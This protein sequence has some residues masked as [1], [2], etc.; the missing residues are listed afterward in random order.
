MSSPN[1]GAPDR[2]RVLLVEDDA[3][4]RRSLQLLLSGHGY[5]VRAYPS[6]AGLAQDPEA[7]GADCLI[8]DLVIQD[9]NAVTLL[10]DL[11][12][13]GW[14]GPAILISGHLTNEWTERALAHGYAA[15][16]AKPIGDAV[17][18]KCLARLLPA[19]ESRGR[20]D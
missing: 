2:P 18:T 17:L 6:G 8:A 3:A 5:D 11:R 13:A 1:A 16:F 19:E 20:P 10:G 12:D 15:A 9:G 7:L 14:T 4:V